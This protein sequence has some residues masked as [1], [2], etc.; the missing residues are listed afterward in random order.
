MLETRRCVALLNV[1]GSATGLRSWLHSAWAALIT[2]R[3][4]QFCL[5]VS[6]HGVS[7]SGQKHRT[8]LSCHSQSP[9]ALQSVRLYLQTVTVALL[10][11]LLDLMAGLVS[12]RS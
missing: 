2:Q 6:P 4:K 8:G 11:L 5:L 12:G 7:S 10:L 3:S 9:R 1:P